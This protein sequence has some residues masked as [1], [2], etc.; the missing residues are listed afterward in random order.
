MAAYFSDLPHTGPV[1]QKKHLHLPTVHTMNGALRGLGVI[2]L[3]IQAVKTTGVEFHTVPQ[4]GT[5]YTHDILTSRI[6]SI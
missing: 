4:L 3:N 2:S 6:T 5:I 1:K